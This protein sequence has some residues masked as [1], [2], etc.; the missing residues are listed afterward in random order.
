MTKSRDLANAATALN[1]VTAA[2]LGY[3]DGVTSAIQTQLDAK[4]GNVVSANSS[5]NALEIRQTGAGNALVVEDEANPDSTPFAI[6]AS[7]QVLVGK[8]T[9]NSNAALNRAIQIEGTSASSV[10][11]S[12]T[13]NS[14]DISAG[15]IEI[16]K[17]RGTTI[18]SVTAV[19]N[20]DVLGN[21]SAGGAD[22]SKIVPTAGQMSVQVDGTVSTDV[23]PTRIVFSTSSTA[24]SGL[25]ERMRI[26]SNGRIQIPAGGVLESPLVQN[27]QTASYTLVLA[28]AGKL[29]EISNASANNLTVP[30]NSSVAYPVGTQINILQTG[31]GQTTVVATGGVTI[32]GTPGLK[33]RAQ[34][35]S[36]TLIKRATDTWVLVGDL[37]A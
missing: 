32:N 37:A 16:A 9:A 17:S 13:R 3:V 24:G 25:N 1:A 29:V 15:T 27:Q 6:T 28:D 4:I 30:L 35:S 23:V 22:G 26:D 10:G 7:G 20:N 2:E 12:V 36:A 18:G 19:Q 8:T 21:F 33:L 34:W 5:G 31:A 14:N 11:V